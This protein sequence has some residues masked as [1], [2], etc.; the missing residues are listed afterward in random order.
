MTERSKD[1][2]SDQENKREWAKII[3]GYF[4]AMIQTLRLF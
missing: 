1:R 2:K 4:N 3:L